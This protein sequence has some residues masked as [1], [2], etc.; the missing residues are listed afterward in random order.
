[1]QGLQL[2]SSELPA[3]SRQLAD[4]FRQAHPFPWLSIDGF[5]EPG[6]AASLLEEFPPFEDGDF[7]GDDG[8][9][10]G[11]ST[12]D[13]PARLGPAFRKLDALIQGR[14]FLDL[15]GEM[16]GIPDLIYDPFY[17]GGG[18]HE[19]RSGQTL[20][21]HIDFNYHPSERWHRRLNLIIYLNRTWDPAWGGNIEL[22]TDPHRQ[23]EPDV[24]VAP[25]F[26]RCV[27]FET[28]ERSWHG[29]DTLRIPEDAPTQSRR[30]IALYFYTRDRPTAEIAGRHTTHYVKRQLPSRFQPGHTLD[31]ADVAELNAL[32]QGRDTHI[33]LQ[34]EEIARLLQA[35]ERGLAGK[36]LYLAK[37]AYVRMRR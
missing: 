15:L 29:F 5:L 30:S 21:P 13:R 17:L 4:A 34:Y 24:R 7:I 11:K 22:F 8:R 28:S 3:R 12:H 27:V 26:N 16:T 2:L 32:L 37:R 36:L 33:R 25:V 20:D 23:P 31:E 6:F 10:G 1:M 14:E 18:T 19:N 9:P 35:Q